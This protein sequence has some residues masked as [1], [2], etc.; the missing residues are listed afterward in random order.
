VSLALCNLG[1]LALKNGEFA[2]AARDFGEGLK[3]AKERGD[4]RVAAECLQGLAAVATV[5]GDAARAA[6]LFAAGEALL[7]AIGATPTAIEVAL[8]AEYVPQARAALG[9]ERFE[10]ES[11]AG[12]SEGPDAAIELALSSAPDAGLVAATA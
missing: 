7:E 10:T 9:D 3:L 11:A 12:R 1:R 4:K 8:S 5:E 6:R 2:E